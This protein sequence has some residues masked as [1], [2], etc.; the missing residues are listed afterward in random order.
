MRKMMRAVLRPKGGEVASCD[1]H[2]AE[3][4]RR[5]TPAT[6]GDDND[7]HVVVRRLGADT[8]R[9]CRFCWSQPAPAT[10]VLIPQAVLR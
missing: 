9:S 3:A 6:N 4:M 2:L 5:V 1:V 8:D 10:W 7:T